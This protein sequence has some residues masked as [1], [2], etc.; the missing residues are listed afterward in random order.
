MRI[1]VDVGHPA[2]VHLFRN[3][4]H[5]LAAAWAPSRGHHEGRE[6][7]KPSVIVVLR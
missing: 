2:H 5:S 3:A 7:Y 1:L 6:G 4:I